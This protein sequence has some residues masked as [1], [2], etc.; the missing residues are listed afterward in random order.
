MWIARIPSFCGAFPCAFCRSWWRKWAP[1]HRWNLAGHH[2]TKRT[3]LPLLHL[4]FSRGRVEGSW[5]VD[6]RVLFD[7]STTL[8]EENPFILPG[9][10]NIPIK[11]QYGVSYGQFSYSFTPP[12]GLDLSIGLSRLQCIN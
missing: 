12:P 5:T 10:K 9:P 3:D 7:L 1:H 8:K 4:S 6:F 2:H 11:I